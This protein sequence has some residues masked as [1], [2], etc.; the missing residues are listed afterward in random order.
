MQISGGAPSAE[1]DNMV[2]KPQDVR[3]RLKVGEIPEVDNHIEINLKK[4]ETNTEGSCLFNF[5]EFREISNQ[6]PLAR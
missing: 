1:F 2:G 4:S 5:R 3:L 6:S